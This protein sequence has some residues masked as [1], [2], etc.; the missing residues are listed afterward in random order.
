MFKVGDKVRL[1]E[2][3]TID[4]LYLWIPC[5]FDRDIYHKQVYTVTGIGTARSG[6]V[7]L[8]ESMFEWPLRFFERAGAWRLYDF[9]GT[10]L[11]TVLHQSVISGFL[12]GINIY[13]VNQ[14]ENLVTIVYEVGREGK[15]VNGEHSVRIPSSLKGKQEIV[16]YAFNSLIISLAKQWE[17]KWGDSDV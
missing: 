8:S 6:M 2:D 10:S 11:L 7:S 1:R 12:D 9:L 3:V 15:K 16:E 13:E 5:M 17:K 4:T 14:E